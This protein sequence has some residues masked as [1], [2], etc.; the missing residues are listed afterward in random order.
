M[1]HIRNI[2]KHPATKEIMMT[3]A[4]FG[5]A[6]GCMFGTLKGFDRGLYNI[7]TASY[8]KPKYINPSV[9]FWGNLIV[10]PFIGATVGAVSCAAIGATAPVSVPVLY[11][12]KDKVVKYLP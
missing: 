11:L 7:R 8:T 4:R 5:F 2:V 12:C 6:F 9:Y 10:M 1:N 3:S